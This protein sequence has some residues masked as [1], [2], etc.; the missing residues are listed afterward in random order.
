MFA[1]G[2]SRYAAVGGPHPN[3]LAHWRP[4]GTRRV[5]VS[6]LLAR[7]VHRHE[8]QAIDIGVDGGRRDRFGVVVGV[9]VVE[10]PNCSV[11]TVRNATT[12]KLLFI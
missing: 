2:T 5:D 10:Q 7:H 9:S 1:P 8:R 12:R 4:L 11:L 6:R 3:E